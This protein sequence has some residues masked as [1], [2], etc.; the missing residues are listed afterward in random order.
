MNLDV[1][2][3]VSDNA[4]MRQENIDLQ[5]EL[6]L[7]KSEIEYVVTQQLDDICWLDWYQRL[8]KQV[9]IDFNPL[10][11]S[12]EQQL[13]NCRVF[14]C[15]LRDGRPYEPDA[16]TKRVKELEAE[17]IALQKQLP[18]WVSQQTEPTQKA[19]DEVESLVRDYR[20]RLQDKSEE[21]ALR[22]GPRGTGQFVP[23]VGSRD[24]KVAHAELTKGTS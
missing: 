3:M 1:R 20:A 12:E 22:H 7:L 23:M 4:D 15:A 9:G 14:F 2:K 13:T 8:A 17:N 18:C 16:I 6:K 10:L 21:V 11:L 24:V 19:F 5:T